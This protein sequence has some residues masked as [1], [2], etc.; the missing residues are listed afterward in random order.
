MLTNYKMS[1][2]IA[3]AATFAAIIAIIVA[4]CT[5]AIAPL[6]PLSKPY[7]RYS[8]PLLSLPLVCP[9]LVNWL[10]Y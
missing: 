9:C 2:T 6:S 7:P 5:A 4:N 1:F 10:H 8:S 3:I